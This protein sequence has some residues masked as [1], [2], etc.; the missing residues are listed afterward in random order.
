MQLNIFNAHTNFLFSI[1]NNVDCG[2]DKKKTKFDC[3]IYNIECGL[4][5]GDNSFASDSYFTVWNF[6]KT[7]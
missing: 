7:I 1:C 4:E 2:R 3:H 5:M 6:S